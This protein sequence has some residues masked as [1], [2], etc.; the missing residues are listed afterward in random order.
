MVCPETPN[1]CWAT[2]ECSLSLTNAHI[3]ILRV[4][5][6]PA[7]TPFAWLSRRCRSVSSLFEVGFP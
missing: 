5:V 4:S 3:L 1:N 2:E 6:S 7:P